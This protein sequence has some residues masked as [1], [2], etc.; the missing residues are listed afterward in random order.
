MSQHSNDR[1]ACSIQNGTV[2][3]DDL[4]SYEYAVD[5]GHVVGQFVV[6]YQ[7]AFYALQH[8]FFIECYSKVKLNRTLMTV[9][10]FCRRR[11]GDCL[12]KILI[13]FSN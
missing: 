3:E 8:Q 11:R 10:R 12:L 6:V 13:V 7:L 1:G 4:C 9:I 5:L 2:I